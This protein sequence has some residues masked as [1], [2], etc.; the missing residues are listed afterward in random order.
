VVL[1]GHRSDPLQA[2]AYD[3]F[4]TIRRILQKNDDMH[5]LFAEVWNLRRQNGSH[6]STGPMKTLFSLVGQWGWLWDTPF[7]IQRPD[8]GQ[9]PLLDQP[10]NWFCIRFGTLFDV[11]DGR[12]LSNRHLDG[13]QE[14]T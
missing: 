14:R 6:P 7:H 4:L 10:K 1:K 5:E 3:A 12:T 2:L 13:F 9:L 11:N 8:M